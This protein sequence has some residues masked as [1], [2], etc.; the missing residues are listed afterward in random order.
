MVVW[1]GYKWAAKRVLF[2]VANLVA[3]WGVQVD[4]KTAVLMEIV[5]MVASMVYSLVGW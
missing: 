5:H 4:C 2:V 3:V 1:T